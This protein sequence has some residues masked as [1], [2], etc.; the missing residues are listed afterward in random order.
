MKVKLTNPDEG[1]IIVKQNGQTIDLSKLTPEKTRIEGVNSYITVST[2]ISMG[3]TENVIYQNTG[4]SDYTITVNTAY[5]TY[6]GKTIKLTCPI[7]GY[8]EINY[9]NIDNTIY[10][11]V[12]Q[13]EY[14]PHHLKFVALGDGAYTFTKDVYYS[15]DNGETWNGL[16]AN[17]QL[18]VSEGSETLFKAEITPTSTGGVGRFSSTC[19]FEAKGNPLSLQYGD[20][21]NSH[22]IMYY[23]GAFRSLFSNNTH[24]VS[25][26][27]LEL[28]STTLRQYC[29]YYMFQGCT[30]LTAAPELPATTLANNCYQGMF[31]DCRSLTTAPE[32]PATT[33][34]NSCYD[35]M[36]NG[37]TG[38]TVAPE[39][40]A[41]TLGGSC[42]QS[43]FNG[44]TGITTA[45]ELPATEL[46][47]GCYNNMFNG[48]TSLTTAPEL[49]ATTLVNN[50]YQS[51]FNGCTSLTTAPELPAT[52][53]AS[54]CY[55]SMFYGCTG[56]TTAPELPVTTLANSC[57]QN[58]FNGCT[59]LTT[60]PELP[61]TTLA[62]NCYYSMFK[63]C[64]SLTTAPELPATTLAN[65]CYYSMFSGC[66]SLTT[67][68]ELPAT[69]LVNNCYQSM[70]SGCGSLNYIKALF[71]TEPSIAYTSSW[72]NG[73]SP[74]GTF[75]KAANA[76][77]NVTGSNGIPNGWTVEKNYLKFVALGDGSYSF[78]NTLNYSLDNGETWNE[79]AGNTSLPVNSGSEVVFKAEITPTS[80][81]GIGTFS[82]TV[83]FEVKG[84]PLS[85]VYGD[86]FDSIRDLTGKD[87]CFNNLFYHNQFLISAEALE[88]PATTLAPYCY[89]GMFLS[90]LNLATAPELPATMLA[91]YC[92][93][94]MF[95]RCDSLT[96]VPSV[97]PATTLADGCY[98][99]MFSQCRHLV[100]APELSATTLAKECCR[101]M[102]YLCDAL[103]TAPELPA[104]TLDE[105][106]YCEMFYGCYSLTTVP[107][108]LPA[109]TL[110][111]SCYESM[112]LTCS[113]LTAA[114]ELPATTLADRCYRGMFLGCSG[115][116][117]APELPATTLKTQCYY[118]MFANCTSLTTAPELP[119]TTLE[120]YCYQNMFAGCTNLNY[121]KALFT[122]SPGNGYTYRWVN[123]VSPTGTF[124]KSI[125][126]TWTTRGVN[127]IPN[128]WTIERGYLKFIA[129][130]DGSY[131]FTNALNYSLDNGSTWSSLAAN[132]SLSVS[133]GSEVVFKAEL[134]PTINGIGT[135]SSTMSF[136]IKGSPMSLIY[137]DNFT[138]QTDLTGKDYCFKGLFSGCTHLTSAEHMELPA[139]TLANGCYSNMFQDCEALEYAPKLPATELTNMCYTY[140]FS[141]CKA[142]TNAPELPAETLIN[143]CYC[144]MFY[145]CT[146]LNY[147]KT[148]CLT[149][150]GTTLTSDWVT[151]VPSG[152]TFYKSSKATWSSTTADYCIPNGWTV[153]LF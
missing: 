87:Y 4:D 149:T 85:L 145:N 92:Y 97:L 114:P 78:T 19:N 117:A 74:T 91:P 120:S 52:T 68:P 12:K 105:K 88:L 95:F 112:F 103:T 118:D 147:I 8:C 51:M 27:E 111:N 54:S 142:L 122:T 11:R 135:F 40:P 109:T 115:L 36:F 24:I 139:T 107:S 64:T 14:H 148:S 108:V 79:L 151:F 56:I 62:N 60:A 53:L 128:G 50:C 43:M 39:L 113:G 16:S 34:A 38:L 20:N 42:Y 10:A 66:G 99:G 55:L 17:T 37:C 136:E 141:G 18:N 80:G 83:G 137:G 106:C 71:T 125:N 123:G 76:T 144:G 101:Q 15:Q 57:Y 58:M 6:N 89:G 110:A 152:G 45:P 32:L 82:S 124:V 25:A 94:G 47:G 134:V 5:T 1:V 121:I 140:M 28:T 21:F 72:V 116:T 150:P 96:T 98:S 146:S 49:P 46:A 104:T 31:Y 69:T 61:A 90:C 73:V 132:T 7:N 33:L 133:S 130:D 48:C 2:F 26:R 127:G 81:S 59:S 131:S 29:Y 67:A 102:F 100:T 86:D 23:D 84:N 119:A 75:I 153:V 13:G 93:N 30:G 41:T 126:A 143:G 35:S 138:G 44:C 9:A 77:W 3:Q 63:G 22:N 129:G 65:N 70:F